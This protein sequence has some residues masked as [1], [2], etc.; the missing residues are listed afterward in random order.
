MQ[1]W[2]EVTT[3]SK[4]CNRKRRALKQQ[5]KPERQ[6]SFVIGDDDGDYDYADKSNVFSESSALQGTS[7]SCVDTTADLSLTLLIARLSATDEDDDDGK[8]QDIKSQ[9]TGENNNVSTCST[10]SL[11]FAQRNRTNDDNSN[12]DEKASSDDGQDVEAQPLDPRATRKA[13][14]KAKKR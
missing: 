13:A 3:C 11:L 6:L 2:D 14:K 7:H 8:Q 4:S 5:Q 10:K 1:V 12:N 9:S